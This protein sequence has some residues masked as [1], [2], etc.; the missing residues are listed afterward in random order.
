MKTVA[1]YARVSSEQQ[2]QQATIDSQITE[3]KERSQNDGYTVLP[4]DV[5]ADDGYSGAT[6][7]RPALERLRDRI[8]EGAIDIVYVHSP[9]RLARRYAYQVLLLDE[10]SR[11]DTSTVFVHGPAGETAED[12]LLVQVQG[13]IAEYE[14]AKIMERCRRGKLH[15]ARQGLVNPLSGAPYGYLYVSKTESE[16]ARYELLPG[17]ARVVRQVFEWLVYEQTSIAEIVRRL[18]K[19]GVPTRRGATRWDRSTVWAMLHNPAYMGKAAFGKTEVVER[20]SLLRPIRGKNPVPR[21]AKSTYRD[22]PRDEWI[23][24]DVPAIVSNEVFEAAKKQLEKNRRLSQRNGRGKRYL[25]QGLVVCAECG[26]A[27]YGK[28]VSRSAA[29]GK[30]KWAYY[31][32]I[33][34][35]AYRFAGGRICQNKQVRVDQL[36]GYVWES[37]CSVLQEPKRVLEEWSRRDKTD[38]ML[39]EMRHHRDEAARS[40]NV[41]ERRLQRLLDAYEAGAV[42]LDDLT[43]RSKRVRTRIERARRNLRE[44]E[45]ELSSVVEIR[46]VADH[47]E[48]FRER[49]R[50]RLGELDWLE[51]RQVIRMVVSRVEID[52]EG[53]TVVYKIPKSSG[54]APPADSEDE[55]G[56]GHGGESF[57][58]CGR[59]D[60]SSLRSPAP[61][62]SPVSV[63][64]HSGVEPFAD[65]AAEHSVSHP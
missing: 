31:R 34:T 63:L 48:A 42:E 17:E 65:H 32:C 41:E 49:I 4:N 60:H 3:L 45:T 18:N 13:M 20:R 27:Y 22:K 62:T 58:L 59:R 10:F 51:Q 33:G 28:T 25:L 23:Y 57:H 1:L 56:S 15:Q 26:Y 61:A 8:A 38:G 43:E 37:V 5:Y 12:Q 47:L 52:P 19:Q 24:V 50:R 54:G 40:L 9:D 35:D 53:A 55:A 64:L 30:K 14:R 36:D 11:H 46:A 2:A 16:P 44:A 21:R 39:T 7:V 6:L 29:K